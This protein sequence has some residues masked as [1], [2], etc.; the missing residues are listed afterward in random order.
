MFHK[1][2]WMQNYKQS[3]LFVW[4]IFMI[5]FIHLPLY[6]MMTLSNWRAREAQPYQYYVSEIH[7]FNIFSGGFLSILMTGAAVVL[8]ALLVGLERNTRRNDF[9]FSLPIRR[10]DMFLAKW[11]L[12]A[13]VIF[14]F[15]LLN[16]LPAFF[17]FQSSEFS[18]LLTEYSWLTLY[19]SPV[20]SFILVYTFA[21]FIGT[22]A[23]EMISQVVLTVIFGLFPIGAWF[24][25]LGFFQSH[26]GRFIYPLDYNVEQVLTY[27][28]VLT[29]PFDH[30][31]TGSDV[32][33]FFLIGL[34]IILFLA[35]GTLLYERTKVEHNGEFLIFKQLTPVFLIGIVICFSLLGGT[36]IA[37]LF[38]G[39]APG[40]IGAF[41]FGYLVF[42]FFSYLIAKRLL[43]MNLTVKNR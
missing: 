41:W 20:L 17:M 23:G 14:T 2:L 35:A 19:L 43:S 30:M 10:R 13:G 4:I 39:A 37:S 36:I 31:G 28:S 22:I 33:P 9:T 32:Y 8:A 26:G 40:R 34:G 5:L 25:F 1:S 38:M 15:H 12:G 42:G 3:K 21:L 18:H 6:T 16:F 27:M 11:L 24:L 29:F 7:V